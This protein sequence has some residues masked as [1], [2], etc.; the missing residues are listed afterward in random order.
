MKSNYKYF[1]KGCSTI[2]DKDVLAQVSVL[3]NIQMKTNL[4]FSNYYAVLMGI[5]F[6]QILRFTFNY[7][8]IA[9]NHLELYVS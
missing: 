4:I 1:I 3:Y 7:C 2:I 6:M 8:I 9:S 5:L